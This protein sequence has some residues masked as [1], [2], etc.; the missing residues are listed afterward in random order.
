MLTSLCVFVGSAILLTGGH[1]HARDRLLIV[2]SSTVYPFATAVAETFGKAGMKHPIV[3]ST[4]TGGGFELFC[5]GIGPSTP[6]ISNASRRMKPSELETCTANGVT[7][8]E[9]KIGYDGIVLANSK[10]GPKFSLTIEQIFQALSENI[11]VDG[12]LVRNAY[13]S[14]SDVDPDLPSEKIEVLGP[15]PT[16]GTRD[17]F[18]ELVLEVGCSSSKDL[19]GKLCTDIRRDGLFVEAGEN[20]DLIVG[21]L[22]A[23]PVAVG[24]FGYSFLIQNAARIQS[25]AVNGVEPSFE[26]IVS[27]E[28]PVSRSLY[29][30]IKKEHVG[31]IPGLEDYVSAFLEEA[32]WGDSGYLAEE[33]LIPL[34]PADRAAQA[35]AAR[36]LTALQF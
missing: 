14:W 31:V 7:P 1:A 13:L 34:A 18:E 25:A 6:D 22:E 3:E 33:G 24:I 10:Q 26:N 11:E 27:G 20:D 15:P 9:V 28:Y 19:Y 21:A 4:G 12:G 29:F 35:S 23:N 8:V 16:S 36:S 32:A 2:G 17:A 30:Y 5:K